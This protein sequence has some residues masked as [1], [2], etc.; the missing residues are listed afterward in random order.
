MEQR[1]NSTFEEQFNDLWQSF[2]ID[3]N[4]RALAS[5]A[6]ITGVDSSDYDWKNNDDRGL[7]NKKDCVKHVDVSY[8]ARYK[9]AQEMTAWGFLVF[10]VFL[11]Q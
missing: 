2:N 7:T 8:G 1:N 5:H 6:G 4:T 11:N 10:A 3:V 9:E